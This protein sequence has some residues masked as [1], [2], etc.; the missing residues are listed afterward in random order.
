[1]SDKSAC[2]AVRVL[3]ALCLFIA[4]I[5]TAQPKVAVFPTWPA[6]DGSTAEDKVETNKLDQP[7]LV[8]PVVTADTPVTSLSAAQQANLVAI[9]Q[10]ASNF[11]LENSYGKLSYAA[12][13]VDRIVQLPLGKSDYFN[14]GWIEPALFGRRIVGPS[15]TV[16]AGKVRLS[17]NLTQLDKTD[18]D[19]D[20]AA[21]ETF[22]TRQALEDRICKSAGILAVG[23]KLTCALAETSPDRWRFELKAGVAYTVAGTFIHVLPGNSTAATLAALGLDHAAE[24]LSPPDVHL[25]TSG[26]QFPLTTAASDT[27]TLPL[28]HRGAK[29]LPY[30]WAFAATTFP[31]ARYFLA[32]QGSAVAQAKVAAAG[33]ELRFAVTPVTTSAPLNSLRVGGSPGLIYALGLGAFENDAVIDADSSNTMGGTREMTVGQAVAAYLIQ[34]LTQ[35]YVGPGPDPIPNID[36]V[37]GKEK[38]LRKAVADLI[39]PYRVIIVVFLDQPP[40]QRAAAGGPWIPIGIENNGWRFEDWT[41]SGLQLDTSASDAM[42]VAHEL[43]HNTGFFDLYGFSTFTPGFN[44]SSNWDVMAFQTFFPHT[45]FWHKEVIAKWLSAE[46]AG[47]DT[48]PEPQNTGVVT[49]RY[50]LTPIDVSP[51]EYD[52]NLV[53]VPPDR[54]LVKGIRLPLNTN[55]EAEHYLLVENRQPGA[56]FSQTLPTN[57]AGTVR[58]GLH[59][60]DAI[61]PPNQIEHIFG[62]TARNV[63]HP[64]TDK[65]LVPNAIRPWES[66]VA[67]IFNAAPDLD[68]DLTKTTPLAYDGISVDI[69][70]ELS[71]PGAL[72]NSK[73]YLVDISREQK[74]FLD[75]A[76]TPWTAPPWQTDDIWIENNDGTPLSPVPLPMNGET[77]RWAPNWNAVLNGPLNWVRVRVSNQGTVEA[78]KV[79]VRVKV[80]T[81]GGI[82]DSGGWVMLPTSD[83]QDIAAGASA[84]FNIGWSPS[85]GQHTCLEAEVISWES[86]FADRDPWNQRTQENVNDFFP[87]SASPWTPMTV[88]FDVANGSNRSIEVMFVPEN[89]PPGYILDLPQS[90]VTLPPKG[91]MR[92]TGTLD[93]DENIIPPGLGGRVEPAMFHISGY[94]VGP[95]WR[96]AIGGVT[97]R[98]FPEPLV[99]GTIVVGAD[100]SG[101][102][103]ISGATSPASAGD[104]I[105]ILVCYVSGKCEWITTTTD[106]GGNVNLVIPPKESGP[107]K[108]TVYP[109]PH[110]APKGA[111]ETTIDPADPTAPGGTFGSHE[112]GFF[113]G[114][115]F[116]AT[117]LSLESGFNTGFRAGWRFHPKWSAEGEAGIVFTNAAGVD[118]LLG[119]L[120]ANVLWHAGNP[121]WKTRPFV[122]AGVGGAKFQS[123][124]ISDSTLALVA[125]LG[126]NFQWHPHIG[127]RF[128]IR[129]FWMHDLF[130]AGGT[131]NLQGNWGIVFR[132]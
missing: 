116:P 105:E 31:H 59:I 8:I 79:R 5:A 124:S 110:Y 17:L 82:G 55:P 68:V 76:I 49:R 98:V 61:T 12:T 40:N 51:A 3:F 45:G 2:A 21:A 127:F 94:M 70:G 119:H 102:I 77:T 22:N 48:F 46:S 101:N 57:A 109:P 62:S 71:G 88:E 78:K 26:A 89:L 92:I 72:T 6:Y 44:A 108:V 115:F 19:I 42:L 32:A 81:P 128:D 9:M 80:N 14:P 30:V 24:T 38:E 125:G 34:E 67:P 86:T 29:S 35:V 7:I 123:T 103:I 111:S 63:L 36:I 27:L 83:P 84:I 130:S 1:M 41:F 120:H 114:G 28:T 10:Q 96:Q 52:A 91:K 43:G 4:V 99:H 93:L 85:V 90:Y 131:N 23:D 100:G 58:G 126:A 18:I 112:V 65:L 13:V 104:E 20:F 69:V 121:N 129:D 37:P 132:Y 15:V 106:S 87:T 95:E 33:A 11:W 73:S 107:V 64:L 117:D 122:L 118:G 47:M 39:D 53:G 56:S 25:D 66:D 97:Y 74:N 75:L 113:L 16:P 50:V 54:T 60:N